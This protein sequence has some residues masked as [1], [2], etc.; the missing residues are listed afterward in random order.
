M[1]SV[2]KVIIVGNLGADPETRYT[3]GGDAICNI[4]VATTDTW[5]DKATGEKKEATEWHRISFYGK[6]AEIAGQYLR[7]GSQVYVEGSLRTR[8]WQDKEGQ[9]RYTTEIRADT[10]QMLGRRE[11]MGG[12]GDAEPREDFGN[13]GAAAA[14]RTKPAPAGKAP[15][16][17]D[18]DDDIPF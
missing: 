1:A 18:I 4:R 13:R 14:S 2:N 12:G 9:D 5:K 7:K 16:V 3:P 8:K 6:L 10:M 11:G 17:M 15:G